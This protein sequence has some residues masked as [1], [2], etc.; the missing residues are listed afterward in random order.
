MMVITFTHIQFIHNLPHYCCSTERLTLLLA[1]LSLC[2]YFR[3][4]ALSASL[5]FL[6]GHGG[7]FCDG[8]RAAIDARGGR[9]VPQLAGSG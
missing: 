9:F 8:G 7:Q 4:R 1:V 5:A 3:D 6:H 2:L